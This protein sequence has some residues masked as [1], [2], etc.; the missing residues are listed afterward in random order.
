MQQ[1]P[2]NSRTSND[3]QLM[4]EDIMAK[5]KSKASDIKLLQQEIRNDLIE[6]ATKEKAINCRK[7]QL[8]SRRYSV[9]TKVEHIQSQMGATSQEI[10]YTFVPTYNKSIMYNADEMNTR[11]HNYNQKLGNLCRKQFI[12]DKIKNLKAEKL[13]KRKRDALNEICS[14]VSIEL[15]GLKV[16]HKLNFEC[17]ESF[18]LCTQEVAMMTTVDENQPL[19]GKHECNQFTQTKAKFESEDKNKEIEMPLVKSNQVTSNL[20]VKNNSIKSN[21]KLIVTKDLINKIFEE[22]DFRRNTHEKKETRNLYINFDYSIVKASIQNYPSSIK[23]KDE[24]ILSKC[25]KLIEDVFDEALTNKSRRVL[26]HPTLSQMRV[27]KVNPNVK[28]EGQTKIEDIETKKK[29]IKK[30]IKKVKKLVKKKKDGKSNSIALHDPLKIKSYIFHNL[31]NLKSSDSSESED[32]YDFTRINRSNTANIELNQIKFLDMK[33]S[34]KSDLDKEE[35]ENENNNSFNIRKNMKKQSELIVI[36]EENEPCIPAVES[37][38]IKNLEEYKRAYEEDTI[39]E[40]INRK[41]SLSQ[42]NE[43][44]NKSTLATDPSSNLLLPPDYQSHDTSFNTYE[45][46]MIE[47]QER[48]Q[49][50]ACESKKLEQEAKEISETW[51]A[52]KKSFCIH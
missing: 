35:E 42:R 34:L 47:I 5:L 4:L 15:V 12:I 39:S 7:H 14:S 45:N 33:L 9:K 10:L 26:I 48:A 44:E 41:Q 6:C 28:N 23:T 36:K 13:K 11:I 18:N 50:L 24:M 1:S 20:R 31:G 29:V 40:E 46:I 37:G 32:E 21:E 51:K 22:R 25:V 52:F 30:V 16:V 17:C 19:I 49:N 43:R 38:K 27:I 2:S 8:E 3:L